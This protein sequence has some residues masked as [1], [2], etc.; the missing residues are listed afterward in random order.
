MNHDL[1]EIRNRI[2]HS[3]LDL[4]CDVVPFGNREALVYHD[5]RSCIKPMPDPAYLQ[6]GIDVRTA[7]EEQR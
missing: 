6:V 3:A 2:L 5:L 1:I 4:L 7:P